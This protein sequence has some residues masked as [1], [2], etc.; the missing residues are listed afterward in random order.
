MDV[1]AADSGMPRVAA[2]RGLVKR[3]AWRNWYDKNSKAC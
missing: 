1:C 3:K 2:G